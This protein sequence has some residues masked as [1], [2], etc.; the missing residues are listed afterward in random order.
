[1][2]ILLTRQTGQPGPQAL[3]VGRDHPARF[4]SPLTMARYS[5]VSW[6]RCTSNAPTM[7]IRDLPEL[8]TR[9]GQGTLFPKPVTS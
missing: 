2:H 3:P 9:L 6:R 4:S 5:N 1:M 8:R 7:L